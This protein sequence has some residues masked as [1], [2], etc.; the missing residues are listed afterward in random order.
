LERQGVRQPRPARLRR[1]GALDRQPPVRRLE[2]LRRPDRSGLRPL[3]RHERH[4]RALRQH[5]RRWRPELEPDRARHDPLAAG[6][7]APARN[8]IPYQ[9][10]RSDKA[11]RVL[12]WAPRYDLAAG[13]RETVAWYRAY[14]ADPAPAST[15]AR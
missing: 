15:A 8:E 9:A 1:D 12:G 7:R 14:L 2:G 4:D 11:R 3:V 13:L 10:L 5:L 6:R